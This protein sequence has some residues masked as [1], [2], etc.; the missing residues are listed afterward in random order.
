MKEF[1]RVRGDFAHGRLKTK[2][3]AVWNPLEH[4]VLATIGFPLLVR[5]L[6]KKKAKYQVTDSDQAQIDAF[7]K[8]AAE[9]FLRPPADQ[10]NSMDSIWFRLVKEASSKLRRRK[11]EKDLE[12]KGLWDEKP[13]N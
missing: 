12:A 1:Y 7:E 10:K 8:L 6:L 13:N 9:Q 3:P 4:I 11:L 5:C 2:Q